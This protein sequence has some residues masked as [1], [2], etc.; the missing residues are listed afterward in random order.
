ME[1]NR[2]VKLTEKRV[3]EPY[4]EPL[5]IKHEPLRNITGTKYGEKVGG[6]KAPDG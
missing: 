4:R 5:L 6:E 3:V 2:S 1:Q